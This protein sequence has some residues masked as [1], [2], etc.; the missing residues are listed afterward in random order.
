MRKYYIDNVRILC[1][2]LLFPFHSAYIYNNLD[3]VFYVNGAPSEALTAVDLCIYPWWMTGL[4]VLAGLSAYYALQKRSTREFLVERV[5]RLLI[6]LIVAI[7][8]IIPPQSYIADVFHNG[9]SGGYFEHYRVFFSLTDFSGCDGHFTPGN[10]W[11]ILYLFVYSVAFAPLMS[12]YAKKPQKRDLSQVSIYTLL[13]MGLILAASDMILNIGGKSVVQF[14]LCFLFGFF[15]IGD[16]SIQEKLA[17]NSP[18]LC[19]LWLLFMILRQVSHIPELWTTPISYIAYYGVTCFGILGMIGGGRRMLDREFSWT[20]Y[21]AR[22]EFAVFLMH[23]TAVVAIGYFIVRWVAS[24]M[25]GWLVITLGSAAVTF[26]LYEICRRFRLTR[27][28]LSI[29]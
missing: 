15:I 26:L 19:I 5:K 16:E 22:A 2:L 4:F 29:K 7:L 23:Q 17:K 24:P 1:V 20:K 14:A 18:M 11:F 21:L 3:E 12:W 13:V 28:L 25:I 27:L 8:I 6:P 9:Y 10:A